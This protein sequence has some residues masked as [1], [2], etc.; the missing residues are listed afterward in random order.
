VLHMVLGQLRI[1]LILGKLPEHVHK[2]PSRGLD[3]AG[4]RKL[5]VVTDG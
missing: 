5:F 3:L 1:V 2:R 4:G